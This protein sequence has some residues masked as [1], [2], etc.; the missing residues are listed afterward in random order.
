MKKI[1]GQLAQVYF[2]AK[3]ENFVRLKVNEKAVIAH[4]RCTL[5]IPAL[6]IKR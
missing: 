2:C 3:E 5:S 4:N 6:E 1:S